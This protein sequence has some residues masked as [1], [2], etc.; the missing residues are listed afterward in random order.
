M[1]LMIPGGAVGGRVGRVSS[2][3]RR[4]AEGQSPPDGAVV[5]IVTVSV[6]PGIVGA[7]VCCEDAG[8]GGVPVCGG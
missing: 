3:W 5:Q 4:D 2:A 8:A 7:K 1:K 6:E